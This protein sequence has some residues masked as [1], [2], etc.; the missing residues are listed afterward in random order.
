MT[1]ACNKQQRSKSVQIE[2]KAISVS[3][4][5]LISKEGV[6]FKQKNFAMCYMMC[7][8]VCACQCVRVCALTE[9]V[10]V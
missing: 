7:Q 6:D 5:K 1:H 9:H 2:Q 8:S 4:T 3:V 10:Y